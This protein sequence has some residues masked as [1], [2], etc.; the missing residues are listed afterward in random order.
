MRAAVLSLN[1]HPVARTS[2]FFASS[3]T[4]WLYELCFSLDQVNPSVFWSHS[5]ATMTVFDEL[6]ETEGDNEFR[7]WVS[8]VID[9]KQEIVDFVASR[10]PENP[11]GEFESYLKGSF[12]LSLVV[13]FDD[14]GPKAVIRFPKPGHTSRDLRDEKVRNEVQVLRFLSEKTTIPVPRVSAWGTTED[15]PQQLGPFMIMDFVDGTSLA[16]LLKEP[17]E[18]ERDEV[19]LATDVDDTK[20]DYV[21]EQLAEYMLQLSQLD[22]NSIGALEKDALTNKWNVRG[23]PLTYNMNELVTVVSQYPTEKWPTAPFVSAKAFFHHLADE[24]IVHLQVQRN[25]AETRADAE[26]RFIARHKF[27]DLISQYCLDDTGPFKLYC[28]DMQ[29]TNMLADPE[30]LEITAILDF[31]FTNTMPA[32]FAYDPPWWLLLLGPDMWLEKHSME[33]FVTRYEPRLEQFLRALQRVEGRATLEW[34]TG[35][36]LLSSR[37]RESWRTKR[38]WFDY[39]IRKSFDVDAVYWNA[40]HEDG[41]DV[42]DDEMKE[43]MGRLVDVKMEQLEAYDAEC[44]L[45]FS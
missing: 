21:Y 14:G 36:Q 5:V 18:S 22:F 7:T 25:L 39:G 6:A 24:H 28:D 9:A 16:T 26:K 41:G 43:K 2:A 13:K 11:A 45:R 8:K 29:P 30:T 12:N 37:M 27:N 34:E 15:S 3:H 32:Q 40:L 19:T 31:E 38:F 4:P 33:E 20:L 1:Q 42:L 23:R 10:R 17:T 35:S 44:K